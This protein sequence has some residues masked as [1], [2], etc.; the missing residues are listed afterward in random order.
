[1]NLL[2]W[3]AAD[4]GRVIWWRGKRPTLVRFEPGQRLS[5]QAFDSEAAALT[6]IAS[7]RV[8]WTEI[9]QPSGGSGEVA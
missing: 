9:A 4:F 5:S 1:V 2:E 8:A 7:G 3:R 6:A